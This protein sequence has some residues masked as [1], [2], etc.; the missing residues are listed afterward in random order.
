M[1]GKTQK[2]EGKEKGK[3]KEVKL[4]LLSGGVFFLCKRGRFWYAI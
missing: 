2:R 4:G 1:I 3:G